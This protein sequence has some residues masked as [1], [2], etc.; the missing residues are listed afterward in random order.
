MDKNFEVDSHL[1]NSLSDS[2]MVSKTIEVDSDMRFDLILS[3][4]FQINYKLLIDSNFLVDAND[5]YMPRLIAK[6]DVA[7]EKF[8]HEKLTEA[9]DA[10]KVKSMRPLLVVDGL[11]MA[12]SDAIEGYSELHSFIELIEVELDGKVQSHYNQEVY[13]KMESK[14]QE[15]KN[16][17]IDELE[18][19]D[20]DEF[21][22]SDSDDED[23]EYYIEN[24]K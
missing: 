8:V 21:V 1:F 7:L 15:L 17:Y 19:E 13:S 12:V 18:L 10:L 4:D 14:Y 11:L 16:A 23:F 5:Q 6:E 24:N 20:D 3:G 22:W 9:I 2:V